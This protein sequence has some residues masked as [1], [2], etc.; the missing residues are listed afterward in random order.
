M[1]PALL[2]YPSTH[3]PIC[4]CKGTRG[5][6]TAIFIRLHVSTAVNLRL[7][8]FPCG[9]ER[10]ATL[11]PFKGAT[12]RHRHVGSYIISLGVGECGHERQDAIVVA[13]KILRSKH[14]LKPCYPGYFA[15]ASLCIRT[16]TDPPLK[17]SALRRF[18]IS[19]LNVTNYLV[20]EFKNDVFTTFN[21]AGYGANT[22]VQANNSSRPAASARPVSRYRRGNALDNSAIV[23]GGS[24]AAGL[25]VG[26]RGG[27]RST[28]C[29]GERG[30]K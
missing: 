19:G 7:I 1:R 23:A 15:R 2:T 4:E 13:T 5:V 10:S 27:G 14:T 17:K 25:A 18:L 29:P 9:F 16:V 26:R 12:A 6:I 8:F 21:C 24:C 11:H 3:R 20:I 30:K 28:G 22:L